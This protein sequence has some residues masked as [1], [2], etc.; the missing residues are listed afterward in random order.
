MVANH[1]VRR[2]QKLFFRTAN[3]TW[4]ELW[5]LADVVQRRRKSSDVEKTNSGGTDVEV[6]VVELGFYDHVTG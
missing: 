2:S 5:T 4:V 3:Q 1:R 6:V